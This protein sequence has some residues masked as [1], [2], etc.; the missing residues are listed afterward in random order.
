ML[1]T[2][3][4]H[5]H[6]PNLSSDQMHRLR[7]ALA[8]EAGALAEQHAVHMASANQLRD[9]MDPD[10]VLERELAEAGASRARDAMVE[11]EHALD[12]IEAGTYGRCVSCG[13]PVPFERLEAVPSARFCV[14]CPGRRAGWR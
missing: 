14:S 11:V 4:T 1:V 6:A 7:A 5:A 3:R 13:E 8:A 9:L 2:E 10:S 12:R